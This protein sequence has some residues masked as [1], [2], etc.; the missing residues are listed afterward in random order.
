VSPSTA[1]VGSTVRP[2]ARSTDPAPTVR[3]Y[4]LDVL[5]DAFDS[6]VAV[7]TVAV[8]VITVPTATAAPIV[9]TNVTVRVPAAGTSSTGH[10][11]ACATAVQLD[12]E[13]VKVSEALSVSVTDTLV[14]ASGPALLITK[15]NVTS[16]PGVSV[17]TWLFV[18]VTSARA[19]TGTVAESTSLVASLS[20][21][22]ATVAVF[23]NAPAVDK[24]A[25]TV[26]WT[27]HVGEATVMTGTA[28]VSVGAANVQ[29]WSFDT[30][31]PFPTLSVRVAATESVVVSVLVTVIVYVTF[32][33]LGA[34]AGAGVT[35]TPRSGRTPA[36]AGRANTVEINVA[37]MNAAMTRVRG[38]PLDGQ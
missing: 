26:T 8:F 19:V 5:F 18:M 31:V 14:A 12:A 11:T 30:Y 37:S 2:I 28:H 7:E 34:L 32:V 9:A 29:P 38:T 3:E 1:V 17:P 35:E 23:T 33:P 24:G 6:A 25:V 36:D 13:D 27:T 21:V 15:V 22:I 16:V 10:V 4:V 20:P